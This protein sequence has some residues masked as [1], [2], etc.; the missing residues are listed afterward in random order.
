MRKQPRKN[1]RPVPFGVGTATKVKPLTWRRIPTQGVLVITGH[2]GEGKSALG[3]WLAQEMHLKTKKQV[4]A[5]GIPPVAQD[6]LPKRGFGKG[7]INY[8][9]DLSAVASLKPSIVICDEAAFLA[10]SRRAMSRENQ[11][12]LKLIAICRHKDHLL[13]FI[14]QH[15]RQLGVQ[16]LMDADLVMMKRPTLLHLRAAKAEFAPEIEEAFMLFSEMSGDTRKKV[17]VV[18]YHYGNSAMLR[19]QMPKWWNDKISKSYSTV[20]VVS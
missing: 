7:G 13:I 18:D 5:L 9:S 4:A 8:V 19:A 6:A 11:E 12:W 3:W 10:N 2:R 17:Y 16:I 1:A 15:S 20:D 14:H